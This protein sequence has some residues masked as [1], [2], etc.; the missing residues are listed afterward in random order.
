MHCTHIVYSD[1]Y[2]MSRAS[3][4]GQQIVVDQQYIDVM[5]QSV[6][7]SAEEKLLQWMGDDVDASKAD[8]MLQRGVE[9]FRIGI[10]EKACGQKRP[11]L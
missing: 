4:S 3:G 10:F 7:S 9:N 8:E 6:S 2:K 5:L 1:S 11:T